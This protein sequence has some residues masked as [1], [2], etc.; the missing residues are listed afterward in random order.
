MFHLVQKLRKQYIEPLAPHGLL[1]E[2][3]LEAEIKR[4]RVFDLLKDGNVDVELWKHMAKSDAE[5]LVVDLLDGL[6]AA[7]VMCDSRR[8][9]PHGYSFSNRAETASSGLNRNR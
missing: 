2:A 5:N 7:V 9:C 1:H 8:L 3:S 4:K 6:A